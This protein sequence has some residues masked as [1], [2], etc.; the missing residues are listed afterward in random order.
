LQID[1]GRRNNLE[2][3]VGVSEE[4]SGKMNDDESGG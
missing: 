4:M 3:D 1:E 2:N